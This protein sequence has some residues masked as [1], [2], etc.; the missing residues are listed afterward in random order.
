MKFN[1]VLILGLLLGIT[2]ISS[3]QEP[4]PP[5]TFT[6]YGGLFFPSHKD[7]EKVYQSRSELI[8]GVGIALPIVSFTSLT[9]DIAFFRAEGFFDRAIDS[10]AKLEQKF[11]HVGIL[12]RQAIAR[13]IFLR[14]AGGLNYVTI[15]Q[16]TSSPSVSQ[17]SLEAEKKIGYFGGI[18]IEQMLEDGHLSFFSDVIYDYRRSRTK[19]LPGDFGGLRVVFGVH[20]I[21]F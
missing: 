8:W 1:V 4:Q 17:F 13:L 19:E 7:F 6:F 12:H 9:G 21:L 15:K 2:L 5:F 20:A 14:F 18:G 3:A 11:W 10:T 16:T